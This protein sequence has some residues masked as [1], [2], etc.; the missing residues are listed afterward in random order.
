M[1]DGPIVDI[2]TLA[3]L[4]RI[5]LREEDIPRLTEEIGGV[6]HFVEQVQQF[7]VGEETEG[8]GLHNVM[9]ED[10]DS[11]EPGTYTDAL[12]NAAP[13]R[14]GDYVEVK[15]VLTH[16]KKDAAKKAAL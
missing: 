16:A 9:R 11:Y 13:K 5:E 1:S 10:T 6:L 2:R 3:N 4:S 14:Q 8:E 15:Q 12:L 7:D